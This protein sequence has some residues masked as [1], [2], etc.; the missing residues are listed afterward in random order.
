MKKS[1][2][3]PV[4]LF[5]FI[6]SCQPS[7][8]SLSVQYKDYRIT[9]S[10]EIDSSYIVFLEPYK[11]SVNSTMNIILGE[12]E[13][14]L[15]KKQPE[16]ELGNFLA[17]ALLVM[18]RKKM[19]KAVDAAFLNYNG[20]RSSGLAQGNI[21][22]G[23]IFELMPF[24][25]VI[26][27]QQLKGDVLQQFLDH[28][29]ALGGWP[30]SGLTM[31]IKDNRATDVQIQGQPIDHDKYYNIVN[32]DYITNGGDNCVMLKNIPVESTG[33]LVRDAFMEYI[34]QEQQG[35]KKIN[36]AIEN[37]VTYAE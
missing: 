16:G 18:S 13:T 35:G 7:Y 26:N 32:S 2:A 14:T 6:A 15:Q 12:A 24:D 33:Y 8:Q 28:T 19:G 5:I 31:K 34:Q 4:L 30:V 25:N 37:R 9:N 27:M 20:I 22:V 36:A 10:E 17:D 21:T 23:K 29:A 1:N 11:D 3:V